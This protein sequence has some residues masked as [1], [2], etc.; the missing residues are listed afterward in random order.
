[1][2]RS[3]LDLTLKYL[4]IIG[5]ATHCLVATWKPAKPGDQGGFSRFGQALCRWHSSSPTG[6]ILPLP[7]LETA[8]KTIYC[9]RQWQGIV[10]RS[11]L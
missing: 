8:A 11:Q 3:T 7:K 10:T 5:L 1:M 9:A 2:K 6:Q 4:L